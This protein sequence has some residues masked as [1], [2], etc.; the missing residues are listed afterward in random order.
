MYSTN[1]CN[2]RWYH[3][4]DSRDTQIMLWVKRAEFVCVC[5][6]IIVI[7]NTARNSSYNLPQTKQLWLWVHLLSA[8]SSTPTIAIYSFYWLL[9]LKADIHFADWRRHSKKGVQPAPKAECYKIVRPSPYD[10]YNSDNCLLSFSVKHFSFPRPCR[11]YLSFINCT[12]SV[13]SWSAPAVSPYRLLLSLPLP[14]ML[15]GVGRIFESVCLSV[16]PQHN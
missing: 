3:H 15:V 16:C 13:R 10:H 4:F 5:T 2:D 7:R 6:L 9:V 1:D 12:L 8:I 11:D 14:T